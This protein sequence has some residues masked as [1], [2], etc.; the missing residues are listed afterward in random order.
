MKLGTVA[1][2]R[3]GDKG[4]TLNISLIPNDEDDYDWIKTQVT[5]DRVAELYAP[6]VKGEVIRY[7]LPGLRSLNFVMTR[8]IGG[9]ASRTL[10]YDLHGKAFGVPLAELEIAPRPA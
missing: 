5:R 2:M 7:E 10:G 1:H 8:A 6:I 4:D 3:T 9:G